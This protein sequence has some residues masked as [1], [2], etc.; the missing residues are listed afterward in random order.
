MN[1][2]QAVLQILTEF[3]SHPGNLDR[4]I[5]Y[6]LKGVGVDHRDRRFIFEI[7]YGVVRRR[8]TLDYVIDRQISDAHYQKN[9]DLRRIL[10]IGLY[11]LFYMDRVPDHAAVNETVNLAKN[12]PRLSGLSGII[13]GVLR[14]VINNKRQLPLPGAQTGLEERLSI[15]FSHPQWMIKRWLSNIGL[16]GTKRLLQFNNE[17]PPIFLRRKIRDISRQQFEADVK[18]LCEPANG[19]LNLY[20]KMKK[21]LLPENLRLIQQGLCIVQAPSSGWA[22]ALLDVRKNEHLLDLC[23]APGGKTTLMAELV[24][25]TGTVCACE[26]KRQRIE[27][28][29]DAANRMNLQNI[30]PFVCDGAYPPFT[31]IFDKVLVD[32]PCTATGILHRHPEARWLRST[33]DIERLVNVQ[34]KLLHSAAGLIGEGGIMVY[35]TCSIEPEENEIQIKTFLAENPSFVLDRLPDG[36]PDKFISDDGFLKI[37]PY[38]HGLDGMFGARLK[39]MQN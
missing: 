3:D 31:G 33:E 10:Q 7:V 36:I 30:Y 11:Q 1:S 22:V 6:N 23:S 35:S 37:T 39:K 13:N 18:T 17:K 19:Y 14:A 20:H 28:V 15:E 34:K 27:T 24:G 5:D 26:M 38:E 8:L 2:R 9:T 12:N 21:P 32:A 4:L 25:E 16:A 29:I